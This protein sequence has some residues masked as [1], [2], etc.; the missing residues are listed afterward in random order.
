ML[1]LVIQNHP[2]RAD[3]DLGRKLVAALLRHGSTF[4]GVGASGKPGAVHR[5]QTRHPNDAAF[6]S[7]AQKRADA[8]LVAPQILFSTR[9]AH[10]KEGIIQAFYDG[11]KHK[12]D[13]TFGNVKADVLA[14]K[15]P[16]FTRTN[17]CSVIRG[18]S[19]R[20]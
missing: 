19:W 16:R 3:S 12:P 20:G 10:F 11:I 4:S 15:D 1:A 6:A 13:T 9:R 14:D 18:S 7:L 8:L 2:N 17:F 5:Q